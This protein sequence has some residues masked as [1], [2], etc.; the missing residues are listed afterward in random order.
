MTQLNNEV[1][2][3]NVDELDAVSGGKISDL[4]SYAVTTGYFVTRYDCEIIPGHG[5]FCFW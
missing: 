4:A 2:E 1:R 5:P 3:L